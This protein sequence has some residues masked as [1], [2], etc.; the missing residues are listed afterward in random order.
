MQRSSSLPFTTETTTCDEEIDQITSE[1][2]KELTDAVILECKE[3]ENFLLNVEVLQRTLVKQLELR[4]KRQGTKATATKS[5]EQYL[6]EITEVDRIEAQSQYL[7][8]KLAYHKGSSI[9][10]STLSKQTFQQF[11]RRWQKLPERL[12]IV[13]GKATLRALRVAVQTDLG[14]SL[15]DIQIIDEFQKSEIPTDVQSI[16]ARLDAFRKGDSER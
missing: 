4:N 12:A 10:Q 2:R 3:M 16:V 7:A 9:D 8:K 13:S 15:T 14:I 5:V 1:L 11:E 6:L